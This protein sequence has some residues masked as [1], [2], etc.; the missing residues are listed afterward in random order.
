M[1]SRVYTARGTSARGGRG[2]HA[3][4]PT[5]GPRVGYS[6][7]RVPRARGVFV[8]FHLLVG[9]QKNF[10]PKFRKKASNVG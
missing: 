5:S 8:N 2:K 6:C 3:W 9:C 4:H 7:P 10:C 1:R